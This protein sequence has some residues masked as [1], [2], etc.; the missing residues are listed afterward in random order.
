MSETITDDK[1]RKIEV[2]K[3]VGSVLGRYMRACGDAHGANSW[4]GLSEARASILSIDGVPMPPPPTTLEQIDALW[5]LIDDDA[6][7]A[8]GEWM[9]KRGEKVR[10]EA[11][12]LQPSPDTETAASS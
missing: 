7:V 11:K 3:L 4:T 6:A 10:D 5:D 1:G 9:I 12:K 8:A 2:R